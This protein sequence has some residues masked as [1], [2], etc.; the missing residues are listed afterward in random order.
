[1]SEVRV[2]ILGCGGFAGAHARRLAGNPAAKIVGLCD[3]TQEV[4]AGFRDRNLAEV[5]EGPKL[6]TDAGEMYAEARPDAVFVVTPH[7]LHFQHGMQALEA[8]CHVFMEKP[9]VTRAEDAYALAEKVEQSGKVFLV[10][11]NTPC[12]PEF[13]YLR[14]VI[15]ERALG[16]LELVVGSLSQNWRIATK[17]AWR[18]NPALSGGG[19]A[20]DSG[21]H[22][23]NSLVWTVEDDVAEVFA[24]VDNCG[25][26]VDINSSINIRFAGGTFASVVI[27]GNCPNDSGAMSYM[28]DRGRVEIDGWSGQ[29]I[30]VFDQDGPVKYPPI[31]GKPT[32]STD[33]F[34]DAVLGRSEPV[35][36]AR[37]GVVQSELMDAIYESARTGRSAAPKRRAKA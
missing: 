37:S 31:E 1:M 32:T 27:G 12:T 30:K 14:K 3:V 5:D 29:W 15:R 11:Y 33:S 26:E 9:M 16:K 7:T 17:G 6:F 8:G 28:F 36:S 4:A 13:Q 25:T 22:L 21:A 24:F 19:Q 35:A 23:L 10:G 2:A 34:I 20:Y 18:Q